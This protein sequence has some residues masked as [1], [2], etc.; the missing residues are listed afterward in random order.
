MR[1]LGAAGAAPLRAW[2]CPRGNNCKCARCAGDSRCVLARRGSS[3]ATEAVQM[4][5]DAKPDHP[6]ELKRIRGAGGC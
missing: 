2:P 4:T 5:W 3:G 1:Q 6:D